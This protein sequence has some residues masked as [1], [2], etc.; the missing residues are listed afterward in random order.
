MS[1]T[2]EC[3]SGF[4]R[5]GGER[6]GDVGCYVQLR[7]CGKGEAGWG[8][9]GRVGCGQRHGVTVQGRR[10]SFSRLCCF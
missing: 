8:F 4:G 7:L 6:G 3:G 10:A 1:A 2:K 5:V 9:D